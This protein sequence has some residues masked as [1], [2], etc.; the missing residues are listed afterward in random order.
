M[1]KSTLLKNLGIFSVTASPMFLPALLCAVWYEETDVAA[2]FCYCILLTA[3]CG[4]LLYMW[5]RNARNKLQHRETLGLV[6]AG[7]LLIAFYGAIPYVLSGHLSFIDAYFE[8]MSG[9]STT[10]ASI[11]SDIEVLPKSLL[12]WRS[13]THWLGGLGIILLLIIVLPFLGAGGKLLYRSEMPGL[14]KSS[15]RPRIKDS[16]IFLF[17][18]YTGLTVLLT[19]LLL[20]AGMNLFDALCH[21]F[22]T[23]A[24][25]GFSTRNASIAAYNSPLIEWIICLF[26]IIAGTSFSLIYCFAVG[27]YKTVFKNGEWRVY[28]LLLLASVLLINLNIL[29]SHQPVPGLIGAPATQGA[30]GFLE[31]VRLVTFQTVST[32]TCTGFCTTDFNLWPDFSRMLLLLLMIIGGCSGS[33]SGGLKVIRVMLLFKMAVWHLTQ[34]FRPKDVRIFRA[35]D[36]IVDKELQRSILSYFV[37]YACVFIIATLLLTAVGIPLITSL[38]A[39]ISCFNGVGPG[40]DLVGATGNYGFMPVTAKIVLSFI[41]AMGRL[42]LYAICAL[43]LP[44]F[45]KK[46]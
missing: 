28:L 7:W 1:N 2:T 44:S 12:F 25:G 10:G 29:F 24:T 42:E 27:E 19:L 39:V 5:G 4:G 46:Y 33:T 45:W 30:P 35:D 8:S 38:S 20:L 40:L 34:T 3:A 13:F 31:R 11:L 18:I 37:L 17:R 22:G 15:F 32:M 14:D 21:T 16:A 23:L 43:F 36:M 41:M 6:G 9:F 26:M